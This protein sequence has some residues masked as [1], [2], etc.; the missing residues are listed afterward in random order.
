MMS[1]HDFV[2]Y[3]LIFKFYEYHL[4]CMNHILVIT[5]LPFKI[6]LAT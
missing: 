1:S 4:Y 2:L 3:K 5:H 6:S